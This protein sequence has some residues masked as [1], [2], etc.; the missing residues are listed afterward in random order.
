MA[1][2]K[3]KTKEPSGPAPSAVDLAAVSFLLLFFEL[4]LIRW[5]SCNIRIVAYFSNV[6][7]ISCFLGFGVGCIVR[8]RRDLF[9]FFP[10]VVLLITFLGRYLAEA[11]IQSPYQEAEYVF[12]GGGRHNWLAVVPLVYM[13]NAAAFVALGQKL[14]QHLDRF[15]PLRGYSINVFGSLLGTLALAVMSFYQASPTVWFV[16]C[17]ALT[18]WLM[19]GRIGALS[20]GLLAMTA[21]GMIVHEQQRHSLWSPYN[22]IQT[23]PMAPREMGA[24]RLMANDDYHQLALNLSEEWSRQSQGIRDWQRTYDLPYRVLGRRPESVLVLGAGTGNDVAAA[25]RNGASEVQAVE[26]DP[27]IYE[28]GRQAHPER[29]YSDP[30]VRVEVNDARRFLRKGRGSFDMAVLGWLDSHRLFSSLSNV[31]QDNFVYTVESMRQARAL[32]KS[33][34][35]LCLSFYVGK[36]WLGAKMFRMLREAFGHEPKVFAYPSGG[37]GRDGQTFLIRPDP[38][39]PPPSA[40]PGFE[41]LTT[42][43]ARLE[44]AAV[45]TDDWPYLYYK[46]RVLH[47]EYLATIGILV[48]L[49]AAMVFLALPKGSA[50]RA[51]AG[52]FFFLGAGFLL[53]E[54]RN[55]TALALIY[56]STWMV[57]SLVISTVLLMILLA[58]YLVERW[59]GLV[60]DGWVWGLLVGSILLSLLW[61]EAW[62]PGG[63]VLRGLLTTGVVSSTFLFA[64]IVFA[65]TF[66]RAAVPSAALGFNVLGSVV[67]GLAEY[68][69]LVIGIKA[70]LWIALL[71]YASAWALSLLT[72]SRG[73]APAVGPRP[74]APPE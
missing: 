45:P 42:E 2:H 6:I 51:E 33:D 20:L 54:V 60:R 29:P 19:R 65:R 11:G 22:K 30:K 38:S 12:G 32:L 62:V 68:V 28:I 24:F 49:S 35:L 70:L 15:P 47:V 69:S 71:L 41:D 56:G 10:Y 23:Q 48:A 66:S 58:N 44:P 59:G 74:P 53:L 18:A 43:Y 27:L 9:P 14:A 17:F 1:G 57:T 25:L 21:S 64:G 26:L 5:I 40:P 39:L 8:D 7:L 73:P 37:Y 50:I 52:V 3:H 34:G 46:D 16:L 31:R 36:P 61:N 55:I 13:S 4:V 63:P 72:F 67:G